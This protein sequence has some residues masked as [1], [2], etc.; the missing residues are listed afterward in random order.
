MKYNYKY[1]KNNKEEFI[2][3][4]KSLC[5]ESFTKGSL[6]DPKTHIKKAVCAK[7]TPN[8]FLTDE[9]RKF[10]L[11]VSAP[12]FIWSICCIVICVYLY[13]KKKTVGLR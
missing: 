12:C 5:P 11:I 2:D 8:T 6:L 3:K 13:L 1:K 10:C 4:D 7:V 9:G